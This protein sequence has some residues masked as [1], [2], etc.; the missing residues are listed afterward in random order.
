MEHNLLT[1]LLVLLIIG[2][3]LLFLNA[4]INV[5]KKRAGHFLFGAVLIIWAFV[6]ICVLGLILRDLRQ[7]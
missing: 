6:F 5:F 3:V 1:A 4:I 7:K 2:V